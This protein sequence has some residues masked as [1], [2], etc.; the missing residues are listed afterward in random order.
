[1]EDLKF[2][3]LMPAYNGGNFIGETLR[4]ILKQGFSEYEIIIVDDYS[5]DNTERVVNSFN[6]SRIRFYKNNTN[7]G[8]SR[9]IKEC[10]KYAHGDI[11]YLMGQDD[12]LGDTALMNTYRAFKISDDIGAVTRPY[13]WFDKNINKPVRAKRQLNPSRDEIIKISDSYE[14]VIGIFHTLDQLSGLALRKKYIKHDF[15]EDIFTC[16]IY[17]FASVLKNHP[18]IF[19]KDYTIAVRIRSSQCRSV[20]SIYD[21]SPLESW[22]DMFNDIFPENEFSSFRNHCIKNFAAIN[23]VGLVQIKNYAKYNYLWREIKLLFI[24]RWQNFFN[25]FFWLFSIGTLIIP[26]SL[27]IPLVDWYKDKIYSMKL[28][29]IKF[30][31]TDT[32]INNL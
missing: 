15:H 12:I 23:Y 10:N 22:V 5:S 31:Y 24:Y 7:L 11:I 29:N 18:V 25:I 27:L 26:S 16:H 28:R 6:D 13:Y 19:L 14:R 17:P 30:G 4:S 32:G 2:S 8:Y 9:N 1:M 3:I 21:K 20:S